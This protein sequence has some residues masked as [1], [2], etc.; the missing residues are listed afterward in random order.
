[1]EQVIFHFKCLI[2][3][4]NMELNNDSSV[5]VVFPIQNIDTQVLMDKEKKYQKGIIISPRNIHAK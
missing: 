2:Y 5:P 3:A 1:M 4:L